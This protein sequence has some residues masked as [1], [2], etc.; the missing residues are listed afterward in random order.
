[1][2]ERLSERLLWIGQVLFG[3]YFI[4][5]GVL[6]FTVP[7]GLPATMGWM[8]ELSDTLHLITGVAEIAGGLGL[9]LPAATRVMPWLVPLAAA[10]L[11]I[12]MV[13]AAIWHLPRGE[14]AQ[15]GLTLVNAAIMA[16]IAYGRW[17]TYPIAPRAAA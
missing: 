6:H 9:I 11:A 1:M 3:L 16:A 5:I 14:F 15:V 7:E 4:L 12:L 17:R 13:A 2:G 8:Y 10:G